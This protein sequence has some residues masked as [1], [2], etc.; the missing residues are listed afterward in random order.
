[1]RTVL[2]AA[3]AIAFTGCARVAP[4]PS[5]LHAVADVPIQLPRAA[6]APF[7]PERFDTVFE[8]V[9]RAVRARG[10]ELVTCDPVFG[11]VTTASVEVD[12]PC[13]GSTCLAR[14]STS[15]KLGY[16]RARVTVTREVWDPTLREWRVP[17]DPV[18]LA[19]L[20]RE[21]RAILEQAIRGPSGSDGS[22]LSGSCE[23]LPSVCFAASGAAGAP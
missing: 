10:Y 11:L 6:R 21:E 12:A 23:T 18:S 17:E 15:V 16:R 4:P 5:S 13:G 7:A 8:G 1:M 3:T 2:V 19:N 20:E 22:R 9:V 14:E